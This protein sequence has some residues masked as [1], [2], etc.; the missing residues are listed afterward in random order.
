MRSQL[1]ITLGVLSIFPSVEARPARLDRPAVLFEVKA[2]A[3]S[4]LSRPDLPTPTCAAAPALGALLCYRILP[5]AVTLTEEGLA[6]QRL[7]TPIGLG[8]LGGLAIRVF[9]DPLDLE[10]L[11]FLPEPVRKF[12]RNA[13]LVRD[14]FFVFLASQFLAGPLAKSRLGHPF[15]IRQARRTGDLNALPLGAVTSPKGDG[16]PPQKPKKPEGRKCPKRS[17]DELAEEAFS[18]NNRIGAK[19]MARDRTYLNRAQLETLSK[20]V[21]RSRRFPLRS[22][23][24]L[25]RAAQ[26]LDDVEA[27]E[28]E[29]QT[30]LK[31]LP[32]SPS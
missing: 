23:T 28:A 22:T 32:P 12:N 7:I 16:R 14:G 2:D 21:G 1:L 6:I 8:V 27:F 17:S 11:R 10:N 20:M 5:S 3:D 4:L 18:R 9:F 26:L 13:N 29:V 19:L 31:S 25:A 15:M 24:T 30:F